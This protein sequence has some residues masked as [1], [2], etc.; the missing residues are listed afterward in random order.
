MKAS[1]ATAL[2]ASEAMSY[3]TATAT[4][5]ITDGQANHNTDLATHLPIVKCSSAHMEVNSFSRYG[6]HVFF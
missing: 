3:K 6:V 1:C 4:D 2:A 5:R